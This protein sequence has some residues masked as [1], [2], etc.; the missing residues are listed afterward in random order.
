MEFRKNKQN[1]LEIIISILLGICLAAAAGFRVFIPLLLINIASMAGYMQL[2]DDF[3]WIGSI[4]AL[5]V[6][7][8]AVVVEI[9]GYY[10]PWVDNLLDLIASPLAIIS[11][12]LLSGAVIID[13]NP[14]IKWTLMVI[15][16]GGT[17]ISFHLLTAKTRAL[18]SL[19]TGGFANPIFSTFESI[20]SVFI[21]IIS[22]IIP[23]LGIILVILLLCLLFYR[24]KKR[25]RKKEL[26]AMPAV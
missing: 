1:N 9:I 13:V 26:A 8:V 19:F 6:F 4:P 16:G 2:A 22:I 21:T 14:L 23:I 11:G 7:S 10:T 24:Y 20:S 15:V 5:I 25:K 3:A 12:I 18:S 17:S